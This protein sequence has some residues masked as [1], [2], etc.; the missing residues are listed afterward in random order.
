MFLIFPV[1]LLTFS[2][3]EY[4]LEDLN[5]C[6]QND[7]PNDPSNHDAPS[8]SAQ[9]HFAHCNTEKYRNNFNRELIIKQEKKKKGKNS[10][11]S[12]LENKKVEIP[13]VR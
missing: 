3:F 7:H 11:K 13:M 12:S 4:N 1:K 8:N 10:L 2:A 9:P 5:K 6:R